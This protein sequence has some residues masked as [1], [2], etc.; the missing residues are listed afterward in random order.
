M[1]E[2]RLGPD[3]QRSPV[4]GGGAG[5]TEGKVL[6]SRDSGGNSEEKRPG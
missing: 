1:E 5:E 3:Q 4:C 6:K 2:D